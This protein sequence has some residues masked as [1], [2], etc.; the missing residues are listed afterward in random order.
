MRKFKFV[1]PDNKKTNYT[2]N[3]QDTSVP[4]GKN[5]TWNSQDTSVPEGKKTNYT[6]NSQD[7]SVP[8]GKKTDY[9]WNCQDTSVPEA[10]TLSRVGEDIGLFITLVPKIYLSLS[11]PFRF[12]HCF[13]F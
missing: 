1:L 7:T 3:S 5:Y 11:Y 10:R 8:E 9:T 6:W 13:N 4:E 2:W 12:L